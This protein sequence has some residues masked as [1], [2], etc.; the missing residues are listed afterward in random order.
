M[1]SDCR[2]CEGYDTS[3]EMLLAAMGGKLPGRV[4][5]LQTAGSSYFAFEPFLK[6]LQSNQPLPLA[7]FLTQAP[8]NPLNAGKPLPPVITSCTSHIVH[9]LDASI[10]CIL[11]VV[12]DQEHH[13]RCLSS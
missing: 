6:A 4:A 11:N 5:L 9:V 3:S 8:P 12:S 1:W 10:V 2:V 7:Q 13:N